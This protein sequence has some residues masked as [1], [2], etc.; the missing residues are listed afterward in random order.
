M[1]FRQWP[2]TVHVGELDTLSG[3]VLLRSATQ[4]SID[5]IEADTNELQGDWVNGGRLDLLIDAIKA[6]TDQMTYSVANKL[7]SNPTPT[8]A[9]CN[10]IADHVRRRTQANVEASSDGDTL[11]LSSLYGFIQQA[12]ESS[13]S[14]TTLTVNKTDGTTSLGTK[15]LTSNASAEPVTGIA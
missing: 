15:T 13:I 12:Q 1:R 8:S 7:D 9:I 5:A 6:K 14:G 10:R 4:T 2:A 3:T 11:D